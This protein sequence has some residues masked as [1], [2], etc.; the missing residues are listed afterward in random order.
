MIHTTI[1]IYSDDL[2]TWKSWCKKKHLV[3]ADMMRAL[4]EHV[5][6]KIQQDFYLSLIKST[7]YVKPLSCV[8]IQKNY[9]KN[10]SV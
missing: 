6:Q 10:S 7:N 1:E 8:K 5:N 2:K 4:I 9:R 3:S